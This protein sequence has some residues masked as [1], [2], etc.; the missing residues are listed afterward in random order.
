MVTVLLTREYAEGF[1]NSC[2]DVSLPS[3]NDKAISLFCGR[4]AKDCTAATLLNYLGNPAN[5]REAFPIKYII[6][7]RNMTMPDNTTISPLVGK[8]RPCNA[9][10]NSSKSCRVCSCRDCA[11]SCCPGQNPYT[12]FDPSGHH[13][14]FHSQF[15]YVC[16]TY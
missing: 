13:D 14:Y 2:K 7:D 1:F 16:F 6:Q 4:P 11:D 15:R 10:S 3:A 8:N 12:Q 5:G 9:T